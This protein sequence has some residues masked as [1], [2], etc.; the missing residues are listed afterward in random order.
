MQNNQ[1]LKFFNYL[2]SLN[3]KERLLTMVSLNRDSDEKI[4]VNTRIRFMDEDERIVVYRLSTDEG[5][6]R[7]S[8]NYYD[9]N[10]SNQKN[11]QKNKSEREIKVENCKFLKECFLTEIIASGVV[12]ESN[13]DVEKK[14]NNLNEITLEEETHRLLPEASDF[15]TR[16]DKT[17]NLD[18]V[19]QALL[20][21]LY[22]KEIITD[23]QAFDLSNI[24]KLKLLDFY[25]NE[26]NNY[27][28]QT[29]KTNPIEDWLNMLELEYG[30]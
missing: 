11:K 23:E 28:F 15:N 8:L 19:F 1:D 14:K 26:N 16:I 24:E 4:S 21:K 29:L 5:V 6:C 2:K 20:Y 9:F 13:E 12:E 18:L 3:T 25:F 7:Y 30:I 17:K 27:F 22:E 10:N